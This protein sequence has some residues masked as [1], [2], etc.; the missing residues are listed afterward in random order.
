MSLFELFPE[1]TQVMP[2]N[3]D[4]LFDLSLTIQPSDMK[5]WACTNSFINQIVESEAFCVMYARTWNLRHDETHTYIEEG[6]LGRLVKR[7]AY[8][9]R[10]RQHGLRTSWYEHFK[11]E[12]AEETHFWYGL[13]HGTDR[14]RERD[15]VNVLPFSENHWKYGVKQGMEIIYRGNKRFSSCYWRKGKKHGIERSRDIVYRFKRYAIS[16]KNGQQHGKAI[17][18]DGKRRRYLR[19]WKDG[20]RDGIQVDYDVHGRVSEEI[21]WKDGQ[22][23]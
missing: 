5:E 22:M 20:K 6:R 16:Y 1:K 13:Q 23:V 9:Q 4:T 7:D 18:W 10:G 14:W 12:K 2:W 11:Y 17:C 21:L 8:Y 3:Y 15:T 19:R